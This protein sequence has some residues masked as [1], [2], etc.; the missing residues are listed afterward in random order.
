MYLVSQPKYYNKINFL[1]KD[2]KVV[3]SRPLLYPDGFLQFTVWPRGHRGLRRRKLGT[4][5]AITFL[6]YCR[7]LRDAGQYGQGAPSYHLG[8]VCGN[9]GGYDTITILL[10]GLSHRVHY[11]AFSRSSHP[12][13]E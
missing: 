13:N 2:D 10:V 1:G 6:L 9:Y 12:A 5:R 11:K 8:A 7:V 3:L 4:V